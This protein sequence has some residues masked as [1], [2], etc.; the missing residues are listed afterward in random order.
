MAWGLLWASQRFVRTGDWGAYARCAARVGEPDHPVA[1]YARAYADGQADQMAACAPAAVAA[2]QDGAFV[3]DLLEFS[4][5]GIL[6]GAGRFA[7]VEATVGTLV[8][9][10]RMRGR[11]TLLHQGLSTLAYSASN[12]MAALGGSRRM[13]EFRVLLYAVPAAVRQRS[14]L[15]H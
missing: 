9:R 6:L 8:D 14:Q 1:W 11:P 7:E 3:A 2:A 15:G 12:M 13:R 10:Q 4:T 5:A